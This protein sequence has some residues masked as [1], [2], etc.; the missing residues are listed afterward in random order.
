M[1]LTDY[2]FHTPWWLPTILLAVGALVFYFAGNR[3]ETKARAAGLLMIFF[4]I[5]V[6]GISYSVDTDLEKAEKN[7]RRIVE[8]F[9]KQDWSALGPLLDNNTSVGIANALT[10]YRGRDQIVAKSK[11]A[12]E[13]YGF[14]SVDVTGLNS[15]QDQTLITIS[16]GI[17]SNQDQTMGV[18]IPSR[19][20]FDYLESADGWYLNEIRAVE[21]GRQQGEGMTH[22]FPKR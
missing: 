11:E 10:L 8:A 4:A 3:Q 16:V 19:W 13:R 14:K 6:V 22:L 5:L 17:L 12:S 2:L 18:S 15:R 1:Y 9:D 21:I 20:E 7:T